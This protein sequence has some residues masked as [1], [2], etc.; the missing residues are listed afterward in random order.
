M[1]WDPTI[2]FSHVDEGRRQYIIEVEGKVYTTMAIILDSSADSPFGRGT[3]IWKVKDRE[4]KIRVLKDLWLEFDRV[5]EHEILERIIDDIK[6][7]GEPNADKMAESFHQRTLTPL[8]FCK[9]AVD[10][11]TDDTKSVMMGGFDLAGQPVVDLVTAQTPASASQQSVGP[12]LP[13]D[14]DHPSQSLAS[15]STTLASSTRS[16][17]PPR[18]PLVPEQSVQSRRYH[19][20]I[21]FEQY[22]T[23]I[24]NERSMSNIINTLGDVVIGVLFSSYD[25][26]PT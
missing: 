26:H 8:A 2:S 12:S 19:Y 10:G 9:L 20:R 3:R 5:P 4:G 23:T 24:Y 21:V 18:Q 17:I 11:E 15:E 14:R 22:A 16:H 7:S 1:G 25:L 6:N 13:S